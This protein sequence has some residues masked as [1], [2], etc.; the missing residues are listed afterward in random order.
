MKVNEVIKLES[1]IWAVSSVDELLKLSLEIP[2][3]DEEYPVFLR[4][5]VANRWS[6]M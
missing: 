2:D 1:R 3:S 4:K 6:D 5:L